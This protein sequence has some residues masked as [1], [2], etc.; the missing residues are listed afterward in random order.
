MVKPHLT[1]PGAPMETVDSPMFVFKMN[2]T[3]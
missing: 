2:D 3:I 1:E